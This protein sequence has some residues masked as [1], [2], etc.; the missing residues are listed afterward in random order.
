M[1]A[2]LK[3]DL[4]FSRPSPIGRPHIPADAASDTDTASPR[5]PDGPIVLY[6]GEIVFDG[7]PQTLL[8]D[9]TLVQRY[10]GL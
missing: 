4:Q 7:P 1:A 6:K 3:T 5:S 10:L 2:L 9:E 8:R